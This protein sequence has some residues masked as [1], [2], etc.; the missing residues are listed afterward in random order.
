M[1]NRQ[2]AEIQWIKIK[3]IIRMIPR[4]H[5]IQHSHQLIIM[6]KTNILK[7][8]L[9]GMK[10]KGKKAMSKENLIQI[11]YHHHMDHHSPKRAT[12]RDAT[13]TT[14]KMKKRCRPLIRKYRK[15][16]KLTMKTMTRLKLRE[17]LIQRKSVMQRCKESYNK[18]RHSNTTIQRA[19]A[20]R[21]KGTSKWRA[22]S[23][24]LTKRA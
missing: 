18:P 16:C 8:M 4:S 20:S 22:A 24:S 11:R 13:M 19:T 1:T 5:P 10:M 14:K 7:A 2:S 12:A 15:E 3:I 17:L 9:K 21:K 23:D 6:S